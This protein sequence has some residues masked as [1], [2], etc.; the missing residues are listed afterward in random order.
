[1]AEL[2][3]SGTLVDGI[4]LLVVGEVVA[5]SL[6]W[7]WRRRGIAPADLVPNVL[8]GGFLLLTVRLALG[9]AGW[10]MCS[11]SLAAAGIA[12]LVDLYR[13]W[14]HSAV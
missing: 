11:A 6:L 7:R 9:D 1:M 5:L 12:H 3:A 10:M 13:R 8:A 2:F 4:L 14:R